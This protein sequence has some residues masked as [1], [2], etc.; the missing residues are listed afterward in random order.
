M[1][2]H[3]ALTYLHLLDVGIWALFNPLPGL[4][5]TGSVVQFHDHV[6]G[7]DLD[8]QDLGDEGEL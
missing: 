8:G 2:V 6:R 4:D 1:I 5:L 3:A 7:L